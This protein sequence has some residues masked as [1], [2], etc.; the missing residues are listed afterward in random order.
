MIPGSR[1]DGIEAAVNI[2]WVEA[3]DL[4]LEPSELLRAW[5]LGVAAIGH[6][7]VCDVCGGNKAEIGGV[8]E[9]DMWACSCCA[10]TSWKHH[11]TS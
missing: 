6:T 11:G 7:R 3:A 2:L 1:E 5:R 4:G 10:A 8:A 9:G